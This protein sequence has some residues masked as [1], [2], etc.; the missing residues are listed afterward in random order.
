MARTLHTDCAIINSDRIKGCFR[1][2]HHDRGRSPRYAVRP[3]GLQSI[4]KRSKRTAAGKR[5]DHRKRGQSPAVRQL[6]GRAAK[7][8]P[9]S[10]QALRKRAAFRSPLKAESGT[11][12][13]RPQYASPPSPR[14]ERK[15]QYQHAE[16][17]RIKECRIPPAERSRLS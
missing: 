15:R 1:R 3:V 9:Q 4:L 13:S 5:P 6:N 2:G 12:K 8:T 10:G 11:V 7:A 16:Q 14:Q 17:R